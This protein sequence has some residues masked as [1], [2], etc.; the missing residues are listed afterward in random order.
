MGV[1]CIGY[2]QLIDGDANRLFFPIVQRF[3]KKYQLE[4]NGFVRK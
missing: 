2:I 1:I 4:I 3:E